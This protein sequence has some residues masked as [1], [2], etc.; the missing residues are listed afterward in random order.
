MADDIVE[1]LRHAEDNG[2]CE[3]QVLIDAADEIGRLRALVDDYESGINW[4]TTC[5]NC[6]KLLD[7]NYDQYCE[8]DRLRAAGDQLADYV[9]EA[10]PGLH[11][12]MAILA[13]W[14]EARR[15]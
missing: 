4:H 5:T 1:R 10:G 11:D 14:Q 3:W 9:R 12:D 13:C 8:I 7:D 2:I 15:G 6:A